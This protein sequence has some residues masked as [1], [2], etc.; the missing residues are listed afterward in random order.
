MAVFCFEESV[1]MLYLAM[2]LRCSRRALELGDKLLCLSVWIIDSTV[3]WFLCPSA[4]PGETTDPRVVG[5][6]SRAIRDK[7]RGG[8]FRFILP[9]IGWMRL[10]ES[11]CVFLFCV[12]YIDVAGLTRSAVYLSLTSGV[13]TQSIL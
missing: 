8:T 4:T 12:T 11:V 7:L 13:S 1:S 10:A 5:D 3:T 9:V 6:P 2:A